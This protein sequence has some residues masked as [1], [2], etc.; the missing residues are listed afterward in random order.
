VPSE[1]AEARVL[2]L[3]QKSSDARARS[4]GLRTVDRV[5]NANGLTLHRQNQMIQEQIRGLPAR[6]GDLAPAGGGATPVLAELAEFP[7]AAA[8]LPG[9]PTIC[10]L[11]AKDRFQLAGVSTLLGWEDGTDLDTVPNG[12]WLL[13]RSTSQ[14]TGRH[15]PRIGARDRIT[16]PASHRHHLCLGQRR[17]VLAIP[18]AATGVLALCDPALILRAV[19][20]DLSAINWETTP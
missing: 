5:H 9:E 6:V 13:L 17:N 8:A 10:R 16:L 3:H 15:V 20:L 11:D 4:A 18:L 1:P 12:R 7:L 2:V 14:R 19:P